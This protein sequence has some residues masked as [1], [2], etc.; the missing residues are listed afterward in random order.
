M[1]KYRYV[2]ET[3]SKLRP[4]QSGTNDSWLICRR[5][6]CQLNFYR[7]PSLLLQ[8]TTLMAKQRLLIDALAWPTWKNSKTSIY[9]IILY[10]KNNHQLINY[11]H[12]KL[13]FGFDHTSQIRLSWNCAENHTT[14]VPLLFFI[15]N[16]NTTPTI[17]KPLPR[18]YIN[19]CPN[20][21]IPSFI[22]PRQ[23]LHSTL[24]IIII[25]IKQPTFIKIIRS[26]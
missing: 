13:A 19:Q 1:R 5:D 15:G 4:I 11:R 22:H 25:I 12:P 8:K 23:I 14:C 3:S 6:W 18:I 2:R 9:K 24:R 7:P 16:T 21:A 10:F 20:K 26:Q 17:K